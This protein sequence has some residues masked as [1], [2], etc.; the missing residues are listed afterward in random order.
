[1]ALVASVGAANANSYETLAEFDTYLET[2]LHKPTAV[3]IASDEDKES[4]LIMGTRALDTILTRFRRLEIVQSRSGLL[5]FYVIRPYW[6]GTPASATQSLAWPRI[7]MRDRNGNAI[8][9]DVNPQAL[10]DALS[11][12]AIL[13][14]TT[15]TTT[16]NSTVVQGITQLSA[17]PV[18]LTFKDYIQKRALPDYVYQLLVPGWLT[19][20]QFENAMPAQFRT[21]GTRD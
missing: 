17:G 15:D 5:K 18:S 20:E 9:V 16:D 6:T 2:R 13:Q 14:I 11:E 19:D 21:L 4:A 1:M 12:M 3:T 8:A 7:G 10:K